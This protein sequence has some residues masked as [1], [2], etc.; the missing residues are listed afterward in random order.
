MLARSFLIESSSK[1]LA[2]RTGIKARSSLNL[3]QIRPLILE[4]LVLEWQKF[5]TFELGER[6]GSVVEC[7]TPEREVGGSIPTAAILCPWARHFT[8]R[9]YWFITQ[10]AVAPSRHDWNIVDWD[11]R[12]QHKQTNKHFWTWISLKPVGQFWSNFM[13][14]I[15]GVGKDCIRFWPVWPWHIGL[16]GA[17]VA[18]WVTCYIFRLRQRDPAFGGD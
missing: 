16:R 15:T 14:S 9:M 10:E 1:L 17:I 12:P 11:V 8:P 5:H 18:L 2:T 6:G 3:G 7:R 4:L 13:C